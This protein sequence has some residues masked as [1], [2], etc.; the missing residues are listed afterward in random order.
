MDYSILLAK[1]FGIYLII[2]SLA[3]LLNRHSMR[4]IFHALNTEEVP[5]FSG[6]AILLVGLIIVFSHNIWTDDFRI[7]IT[8]LG[9]MAVIKGAI[10]LIAPD[11]IV[12]MTKVVKKSPEIMMVSLILCLLLGMYLTVAGF[13]LYY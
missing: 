6:F 5:F 11:V 7:V 13:A 4:L 12:N 9:W 2:V 10:R 8:L 1:I 3:M